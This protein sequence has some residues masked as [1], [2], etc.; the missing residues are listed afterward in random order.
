MPANGVTLHDAALRRAEHGEAGAVEQQVL[1]VQIIW[2][3]N[4]DIGA[5]DGVFPSGAA[6]EHILEPDERIFPTGLQVVLDAH[7]HI[8]TRREGDVEGSPWNGRAAGVIRVFALDAMSEHLLARDLDLD[9][10]NLPDAGP[11]V[12]RTE[13]EAHRHAL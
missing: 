5:A 13:R 2:Q 9:A 12:I 3:A 4:D 1:V 8:L 10:G 7:R 11:A 6:G